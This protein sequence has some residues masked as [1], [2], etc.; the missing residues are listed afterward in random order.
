MQLTKLGLEEGACSLIARI[1]AFHQT[2]A[3]SEWP[4]S[5]LEHIR[6]FK[7]LREY[8]DFMVRLMHVHAVDTRPFL[9]MGR[10]LGMRLMLEVK[11]A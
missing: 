8:L 1:S 7:L 11:I 3:Q 10:G 5:L 9:H 4:N 6:M 2:C